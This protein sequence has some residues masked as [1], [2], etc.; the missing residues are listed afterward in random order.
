MVL[1]VGETVLDIIFRDNQPETANPGGSTYN[2][3]ISLGRYGLDCAMV[4]QVGDDHVGDLTRQHLR[5]NGVSDR[6]VGVCKGMK[7]HISLA[8]L[9]AQNDAEYTFYKDHK[10]WTLAPELFDIPITSNDVLLLGSYYA[11]NPVTR[12]LVS[13]LLHRAKE[14]GAYIYYDINF[15]K[16]HVSE[17]PEVKEAMLENIALA[18]TVR[19]SREDIDLIGFTPEC[20]HLIITDAAKDVQVYQD[21]K[22]TGRYPVAP[23]ETVSTIGAG[24]N[25]N[26]GYI[27]G[28]V[29]KKSE[30]DCIALALRF[31]AN[32]CRQLGNSIT[33]PV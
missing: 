1:G 4:T 5:E 17:L 7:S 20:Q 6:Y 33:L 15:R 32:V 25:F 28:R 16:P 13:T 29:Q 18:S 26:A 31:A 8:F 11:I 27:A 14:N 2:A 24:D 9:N 12:P 10:A 21:G 30:T 23:I 3:M 19:A 22:E